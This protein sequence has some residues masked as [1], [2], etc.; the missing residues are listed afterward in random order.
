MSFKPEQHSC[1]N[2]AAIL[3][4]IVVNCVCA[5]RTQRWFPNAYMIRYKFVW[6]DEVTLRPQ[7]FVVPFQSLL[8]CNVTLPLETKCENPRRTTPLGTLPGFPLLAP[9]LVA[10]TFVPWHVV[11]V[12]PAWQTNYSYVHVHTKIYNQSDRFGQDPLLMRKS[13]RF[14]YCKLAPVTLSMWLHDITKCG[15][16]CK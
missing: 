5:L 14:G 8:L 4:S 1:Q 9:I 13:M 10:L 16:K 6:S 2:V 3:E 11:F 12:F 7:C 15:H